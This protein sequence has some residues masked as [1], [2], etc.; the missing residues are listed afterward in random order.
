MRGQFGE[1]TQTCH[2]N[3]KVSVLFYSQII[4]YGELGVWTSRTAVHFFVFPMFR[5]RPIQVSNSEIVI[6]FHSNG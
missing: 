6:S 4:S 3:A 5:V 1:G 2:W